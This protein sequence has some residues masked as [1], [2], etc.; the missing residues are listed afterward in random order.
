MIKIDLLWWKLLIQCLLNKSLAISSKKIFK[1]NTSKKIISYKKSPTAW[2]GWGF[3]LFCF[4]YTLHERIDFVE[5]RFLAVAAYIT[6][7]QQGT[8][9]NRAPAFSGIRAVYGGCTITNVKVHYSNIRY[10]FQKSSLLFLKSYYLD[11]I[12][13]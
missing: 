9:C 4:C 12:Y 1:N 2:G 3:L 11:I 7:L 8:R 13:L 10:Y 5:L 6:R